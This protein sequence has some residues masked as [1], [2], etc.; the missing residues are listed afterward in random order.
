M[1]FLTKI[2]EIVLRIKNDDILSEALSTLG[3]L[4]EV[5]TKEK[6]T[7]IDKT[8]VW[9][10]AEYPT[11]KITKHQ[12]LYEAVLASVIKDVELVN[13]QEYYRKYLKLLYD[14]NKFAT[15]LI[16]APDMHCQ[17]PQD[18]CPLGNLFFSSYRKF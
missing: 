3:A 15:L 2:S 12:E 18:A 8:L 10:F 9:V 5:S 17:F 1:H 16:A 6:R 4:R 14:S 11:N 13:R 7:L